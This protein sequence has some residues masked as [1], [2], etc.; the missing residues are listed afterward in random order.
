[1]AEKPHILR[2]AVDQN[3]EPSAASAHSAQGY[4]TGSSVGNPIAENPARSREKPRN[5]LGQ[6]RKQGGI[7]ALFYLLPAYD[8][9][10]EWKMPD[11]GFVSCSGHDDLVNALSP[12]RPCSV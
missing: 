6:H 4:G 7:P 2:M 3:H 5:L 9:H 8:G 12:C 10:G 1:M 11:V